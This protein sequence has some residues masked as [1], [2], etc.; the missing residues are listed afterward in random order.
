MNVISSQRVRDRFTVVALTAD[1]ISAAA[2]GEGAAGVGFPS[3]CESLHGATTHLPARK[4]R[5]MP[6]LC[7]HDVNTAEVIV[8]KYAL[9]RED[10]RRLLVD[11]LALAMVAYEAQRRAKI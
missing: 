6:L 2:M 9:S 1:G 4:Y 5:H 3:S 8:A 10:R 11:L 7:E